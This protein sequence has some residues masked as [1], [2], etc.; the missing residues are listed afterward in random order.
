MSEAID[1]EFLHFPFKVIFFNFKEQME[2]VYF[3]DI[4]FFES[5][6]KDDWRAQ[7]SLLNALSP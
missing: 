2:N 6:L 7:Q 4:L 3:D 1:C 5:Q